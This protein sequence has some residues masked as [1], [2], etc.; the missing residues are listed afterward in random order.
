MATADGTTPL[1]VAS[2][3]GHEDA[4]ELLLTHGGDAFDVTDLDGNS[5]FDLATKDCSGLLQAYAQQGKRWTKS[6]D[7]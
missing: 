6:N 5:P 2:A 3:W 4:L 7:T 1:H